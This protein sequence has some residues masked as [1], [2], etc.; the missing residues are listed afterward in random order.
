MPNSAR[1]VPEQI[2][3]GRKGRGN[4]SPTPSQTP[5]TFPK[6]Q[7]FETYPTPV[8]DGDIDN[9][10][11][12]WNPQDP[13]AGIRVRFNACPPQIDP[14]SVSFTVKTTED[15]WTVTIHYQY[16]SDMD[17]SRHQVDFPVDV[18]R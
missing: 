2:G 5:S 3:F 10:P 17:G 8:L 18:K 11:S 7:H 13:A 9:D 4:P 16:R 14:Q 12:K 6:H 1:E 15:G